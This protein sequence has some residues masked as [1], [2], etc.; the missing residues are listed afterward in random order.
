MKKLSI[1]IAL[2]LFFSSAMFGQLGV[3]TDSSAPDNS[4]M[5]DVKS[6]T[7]GMLIPR[8]TGTQR[9]SIATPAEGLLVY[10]TDL[11]AFMYYHSG[12]WIL[13]M[14]SSNGWALAG[15]SGTTPATNFLGTTDNQSLVFRV[16]NQRSGLIE[17][18]GNA[19]FGY[20]ALLNNAGGYWNCAFGTDALRGNT[21]GY[22]NSAFGYGV[23]VNSNGNHNCGFGANAL[24]SNVSGN[25]NIGIGDNAMFYNQTGNQNNA[26]GAYSL[27]KNYS[28][29]SNNA[30]GAN[31]LYNNYDGSGN[32][33]MGDQAL[34]AVTTGSNNT[35][36]GNQ[37]NV[38][39]VD[40]S[41]STAIGNGAVAQSSN[42]MRLGNASVSSLY[43]MGAYTP[44]TPNP[45]NVYVS[46]T[47][48]IMRTTNAPV[49][50]S[51]CV[52]F[53]G[54]G[55]PTFIIGTQEWMAENLRVTHYRN[56]DAIPWVADGGIWGAITYGAYCWFNNDQVTNA[57]YGLLYNHYTVGDSRGL[58]P[59]GWHVPSDGE[60]TMLTTY[61]G[62]TSVAGGKM[63]SVS[64]LWYN[65]NVDATN[66][67]GFSG[68]PGAY[69]DNT[70]QFY[71]PSE[72]YF[73]YP[74]WWWTSSDYC[75]VSPC[76]HTTA[77]YRALNGD[78][79]GVTSGHTGKTWG[80]SVRC[81]RD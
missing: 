47:G 1:F 10:D 61:L 43:C 53:D 30:Y 49:P 72:F 45:A 7:K 35:A 69:R 76:P 14:N 71:N 78:A 5:L 80:L 32:V 38:T 55:Y 20:K 8:M 51:I 40:Q 50:S 4:A 64:A 39:A 12:N 37:A 73:Y 34:Y 21:A 24:Y 79:A 44:T 77:Y 15:N 28:G 31:A 66:N 46:S 23:L 18:G 33:A 67:S 9:F 62:G 36:I 68:L 19:L 81:V 74:G 11:G 65:P 29:T 63:K 58:C 17:T 2:L 57:K 22:N 27:W 56:G 26:T 13:S 42:E 54:N 3:N 6:I 25:W 48:Q 16:N 75:A 60:W 70:G 52:D 41:N 59:T